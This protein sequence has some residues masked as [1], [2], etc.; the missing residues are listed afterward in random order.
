MRGLLPDR[1]VNRTS[2]GLQAADWFEGMG[3]ILPQILAEIDLLEQS[4]IARRVLDL[5]RM[6][7]LIDT[8]PRDGFQTSAVQVPY[9]YALSRGLGAGRFLRHFDPSAPKS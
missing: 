3:A 6:R 8:W 2:R 7:R 9:H 1:T 5:E 4:P